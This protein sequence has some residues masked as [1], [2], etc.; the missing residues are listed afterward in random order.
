MAPFRHLLSPA[1]EFIWTNNLEDAFVTSKKKIIEM[2]QIGGFAFDMELE[3]CLSTEYSKDL[4]AE[5]M[6]ICQDFTDLLS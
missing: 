2:I 5:D 6:K 4:V 1:T 3:T